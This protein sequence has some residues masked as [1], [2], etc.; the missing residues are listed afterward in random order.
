VLDGEHQARSVAVGE[1]V[2]DELVDLRCTAVLAESVFND[3]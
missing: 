1:E 3:Y 2:G